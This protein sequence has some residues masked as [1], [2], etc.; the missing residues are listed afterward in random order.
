MKFDMK[1]TFYVVN[2]LIVFRNTILK[3]ILIN[4]VEIDHSK[5]Y[6]KKY[7]I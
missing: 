7:L 5:T 6:I 2:I 1:Q 3:F 4:L